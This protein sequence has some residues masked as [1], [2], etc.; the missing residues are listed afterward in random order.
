MQKSKCGLSTVTK[1]TWL[2]LKFG[3]R[4]SLEHPAVILRRPGLSARIRR[5]N[6][7][8]LHAD[9]KLR[10]CLQEAWRHQGDFPAIE[11]TAL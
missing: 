10:M 9:P 8:S 2:P 3:G 5:D 7:I 1:H 6:H 11:D 4:N